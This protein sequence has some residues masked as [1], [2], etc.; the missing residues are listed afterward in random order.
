M[1]LEEAKKLH[2]GDEV[3]WTDPDDGLCSCLYTISKIEIIEDGIHTFAKI[4]DTNGSYN[5][6]ECYLDELS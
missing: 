5:Y 1:T 4:W 2:A 3:Y 6:N